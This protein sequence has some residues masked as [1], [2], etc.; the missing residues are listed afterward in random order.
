MKKIVI[1]VFSVFL[2]VFLLSQASECFHAVQVH[3][4]TENVMDP[5]A[6]SNDNCEEDHSVNTLHTSFLIPFISYFTA[7][8]KLNAIAGIPP[9]LWQPPK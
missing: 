4:M 6:Q 1:I 8:I 9:Y 7:N 2:S 5:A 3:S